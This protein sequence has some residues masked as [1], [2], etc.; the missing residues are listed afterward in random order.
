MKQ[1]WIALIVLLTVCAAM[2]P[3]GAAA[4]GGSAA[5]EPG[6]V[7]AAAAPDNT[8]ADGA[9]A[10]VDESSATDGAAVIVTD[11]TATDA[12]ELA[13]PSLLTLT[14]ASQAASP[15]DAGA[16]GVTLTWEAVADAEVYRVY[17]RVGTGSWTALTDVDDNRWTDV[18]VQ[19][20]RTY[21][22]TVSALDD[23]GR[24]GP[25]DPNGL[26]ITYYELDAPAITSAASDSA[27]VTIVWQGVRGATSYQV[28]RRVSGGAWETLADT[29]GTD[30][31]DSAVG[32]GTT[33]AYRVRAYGGSWSAWSAAVTVTTPNPFTDVSDSASYFTA[34]MWAYNNGIV[35]GTSAT[36]FSP[37]SD[38]TRG[39]FALM[40]YRLAGKPDVTGLEN[41]FK[42][43][44]KS[45]AY[46]RA[47][48]WAYA[49]G[50]IKGTSA[51]KFSPSGSITRAQIVIMLYRMADRP[52]VSGTA[53]P[54]TDVEK[55]SSAYKSVLWAYEQGIVKG[56][57]DGTT[58]SPDANCTR[59]QLVTILYRFNNLIHFI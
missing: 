14:R 56:T 5:A 11:G 6:L 33:Y 17:R 57:G 22:Y 41:P 3:A 29:A 12:S 21:T 31:A 18:S 36:T 13:V 46:Y 20:G 35:R 55:G 27:G 54:F 38:C 8:I 25:Y 19:T 16:V 51:T 1:K 37:G 48:L 4:L 44:K 58:F 39:Q 28:A 47:V 34:V 30:Y 24:P 40:L 15:S 49:Q 52:A 9:A 50:I 59:Y 23:A 53:S 2:L 26:S 45:D 7:D 10:I 42:D 43:V 32:A